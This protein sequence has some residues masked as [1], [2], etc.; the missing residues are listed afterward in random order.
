MAIGYPEAVCLCNQMQDALV[1][2]QIVATSVEDIAKSGG[3]WRLGSIT[4]EP[5]VFQE[6]LQGSVVTGAQS[7]A[8]SVFLTTSTGHALVVGYFS[9]K[10]LYHPP[11]VKPPPRACLT[12][13]FSDDSHLTVVISL[14][15]LVRALT[16][17]EIPQYVAQWYGRAIEPSSAQY[18][19]DGF[20][21]AVNQV[22]EARLSV[23]KFLTAFEPGYYVSGIETGY[24]Q[25]IL[26]RARVHPKRRVTSLSLDEQRACYDSV[27]EVMAEAICQGGRY[28]ERDLFD[29]PGGFVPHVCRKTLGEPCPKCGTRIE[30]LS[31][32]GGA[33]Y[34]CPACQPLA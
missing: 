23:K 12:V 5:A 34:V 14:W 27:N 30:K 25:E 10:L 15:G 6:R 1:G 24:A 28:D 22:E 2:N 21:D 3:S 20:R 18:T 19:W 11:G 33:C 9:G 29:E 31:F 8:N 4:Q 7:V 16:E 26:Y 13:R 32:E 17:G